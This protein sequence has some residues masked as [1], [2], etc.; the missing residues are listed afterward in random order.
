M[1]RPGHNSNSRFTLKPSE[2]RRLINAG[3]DLRERIL[4]R[5]MVHCGLRR[6]ET[7][8]LRVERIDWERRRIS[9]VGKGSLVGAIPLPADLMQDIRFY[10]GGRQEGR[11][12]SAKRS[13][14]RFSRPL[15]GKR[16]PGHG[17]APPPITS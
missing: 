14:A 8:N 3:Q 10:P 1:S 9:F 15:T 17:S 16:W 12:W 6:E 4:V 2:V 11:R 13:S 7:A 5:L